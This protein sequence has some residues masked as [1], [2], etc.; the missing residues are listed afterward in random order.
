MWPP[1]VPLPRNRLAASATGGASP[2]SPIFFSRHRKENGRS[3]SKE[4]MLRRT[5][6]CAKCAQIR[7]CSE[8]STGVVTKSAWLRFR[9]WRK[10]RQLPCSSFSHR[11]R[12]AGLRWEPCHSPTGCAGHR[13]SSIPC[14]RMP[15]CG[16]CRG[17]RPV[18]TVLLPSRS[19]EP[20]RLLRRLTMTAQVGRSDWTAVG[21]FA[22][23]RMSRPPC[24]EAE[25]PRVKA[26]SLQV[27]TP[28]SPP[29]F[30]MRR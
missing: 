14:R 15:D 12:C 9:L 13:H 27:R 7:E 3:R 24:G 23:L 5:I 8:T 20:A 19:A 18:R 4:K 6:G 26:Q 2:V 25:R 16:G 30:G 22:A 10:L 28:V 11:K 29:Q 21:G 1:I 17:C